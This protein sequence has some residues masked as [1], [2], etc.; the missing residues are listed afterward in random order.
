MTLLSPLIFRKLS[1]LPFEAATLYPLA[2]SLIGLPLPFGRRG[3]LLSV[4][5]YPSAI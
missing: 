5:S 4:G 1:L 2:V 3:Y